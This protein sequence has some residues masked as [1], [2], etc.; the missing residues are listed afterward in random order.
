LGR[1]IP[2]PS[3]TALLGEIA[4][5][6]KATERLQ[7]VEKAAVLTAGF[8]RSANVTGRMCYVPSIVG[9]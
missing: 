7:I 2:F 1:V 5:G 4:G 6:A 9:Q 3:P 8:G